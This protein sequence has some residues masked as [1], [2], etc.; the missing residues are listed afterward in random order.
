MK[1]NLDFYKSQSSRT[2]SVSGSIKY[3]KLSTGGVMFALTSGS[4]TNIIASIEP[5]DHSGCY[6][7][8]IYTSLMTSTYGK[9]DVTTTLCNPGFIQ[10]EGRS[11]NSNT[12]YV[13][14]AGM[15]GYATAE[16]GFKTIKQNEK[17][18]KASSSTYAKNSLVMETETKPIALL[19]VN[20]PS[21]MMASAHFQ[22]DI[23]EAKAI[24][25]FFN[26]YLFILKATIFLIFIYDFDIRK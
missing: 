11:K 20:L 8:K 4:N 2:P 17:Q 22:Y 19:S 6:G 5:V 1:V 18:L 24:K 9:Y 3:D 25:V 14:V 21:S 23:K 7:N 10:I 26:Y 12:K 16:L 15:R 13:A